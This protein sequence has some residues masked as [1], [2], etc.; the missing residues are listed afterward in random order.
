MSGDLSIPQVT[1]KALAL[2]T[3][4][5]DVIANKEPSIA[6]KDSLPIV[7]STPVSIATKVNQDDIDT[8]EILALSVHEANKVMETSSSSLRFEV[9]DSSKRV[10]IKIV[11]TKNGDIIRQ[12]PSE[13]MLN[14]IHGMDQMGN[15]GRL[16]KTTA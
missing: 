12:I 5:A 9:D 16:L 7:K 13:E 10:V 2:P 11:D 3:P 14:L 15:K 1:Q 4:S 8:H 6:R